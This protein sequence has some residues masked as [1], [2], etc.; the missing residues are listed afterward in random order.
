[1]PARSIPLPLM[2]R[3]SRISPRIFSHRNFHGG[4]SSPV[5]N[6]A[7]IRSEQTGSINP[8]GQFRRDF[9]VSGD[10][11]LRFI[12]VIEIFTALYLLLP[13]VL[14]GLFPLSLFAIVNLEPFEIGFP[15]KRYL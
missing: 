9:R 11:R 4:I 3:I 14:R 8:Q 5:E 1:M 12:F 13:L 6:E 7:W 15:A 2:K 10:D